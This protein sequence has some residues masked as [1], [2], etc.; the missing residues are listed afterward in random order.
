MQQI[1]QNNLGEFVTVQEAINA[2][3]DFRKKNNNFN[4]KCN[5]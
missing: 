5:L 4:K 1:N 3:S 2:V